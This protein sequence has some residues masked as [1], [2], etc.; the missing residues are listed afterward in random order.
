MCAKHTL[1]ISQSEA[2]ISK[3]TL[4]LTNQ[5]RAW[6]RNQTKPANQRNAAKCSTACINALDTHDKN[7]IREALGHFQSVQVVPCSLNS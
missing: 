7:Y 1:K 5:H 3:H 4:K 6:A 2:L